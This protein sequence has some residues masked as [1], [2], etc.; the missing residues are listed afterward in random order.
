MLLHWRRA[1][2]V[3]AGISQFSNQHEVAVARYNADGSLDGS[4]GAGGTLQFTDATIPTTC[5]AFVPGFVEDASALAVQPDGKIVL[6]GVRRAVSCWLFGCHSGGQ[7]QQ[8]FFV[9][10]FDTSGA[11]DRRSAAVARSPSIS[12][13]DALT[14]A[15]E[16]RCRAT[17]RSSSPGTAS[18]H[19]QPGGLRSRPARSGRQ[20][21][22]KLRL[23]RKGPGGP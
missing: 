23:G 4:F 10:R 19:D 17:A 1:G 6:A 3:V 18:R 12:G 13:Q 11:L 2:N 22:F 14:W 16:W 15:R 5:C 7:A 21:R 9:A 20:P 8:D